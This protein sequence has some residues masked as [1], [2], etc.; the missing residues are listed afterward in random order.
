MEELQSVAV[1]AAAGVQGDFR[2]VVRQGAVKPPRR[3]VS[4]IEAESWEAATQETG[5]SQ[6]DALPWHSRRANLCVSGLRLPRE[7]GAIVA[8][9]ATCRIEITMECDPCSRM[10]EIRP[11]LT[12][13]LTPDWR[14]GVLGRVVQDGEIAVGDEV[15]IER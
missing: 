10:D 3:Q 7:P 6:G 5:G 13:A 11:G 1:T 14:G 2:G 12:A 8:I 15:R 9:G 4:I